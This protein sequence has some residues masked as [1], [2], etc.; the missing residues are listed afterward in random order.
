MAGEPSMTAGGGWRDSKIV[1]GVHGT[2]ASDAAL[3]WAVQEARLRGTRLHLVLAHDRGA[4]QRAPYARPEARDDTDAD[5]LAE[6]AAR[7]A[8]MLPADRVTAVL[9]DGL[10]AKVLAGSA[11][12][13]ELLVLGAARSPGCMADVIGPVARACLRHAPCPVVIVAEDARR[14]AVIPGPRSAEELAA[15]WRDGRAAAPRA[16]G[17]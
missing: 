5:T 13:A 10:P 3:E 12:G 9:V 1:V 8:R 7:T 16:A 2:A 15:A 14:P 17:R 6:A 11:P 4:F